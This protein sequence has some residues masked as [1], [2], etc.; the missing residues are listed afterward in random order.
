VCDSIV[1]CRVRL[2]SDAPREYATNAA[3]ITRCCESSAD[4][5]HRTVRNIRN[6]L[7]QYLMRQRSR[8]ALAKE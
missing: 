3:Q 5:N 4:M 7:A 6:R 2:S 8:V 1:A